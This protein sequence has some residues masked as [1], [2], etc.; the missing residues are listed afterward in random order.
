MLCVIDAV[1]D[2]CWMVDA[3]WR[4]LDGRCWMIDAGMLMLSR[5]RILGAVVFIAAF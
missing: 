4:M 3:G 1:R 2:R 5:I